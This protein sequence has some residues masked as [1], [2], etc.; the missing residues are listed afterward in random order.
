MIGYRQACWLTLNR[1]S[2]LGPCRMSQLL[3]HYHGVENI[4]SAPRSELQALISGKNTIVNAILSGP[5]ESMLKTESEWLAH[6]H[7]QG[8]AHFFARSKK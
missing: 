4:F 1:I 2:G 8:I 5:D 7:H 6:D 3:S